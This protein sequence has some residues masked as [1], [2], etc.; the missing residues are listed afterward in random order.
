MHEPTVSEES[1]APLPT[2]EPGF[3]TGLRALPIG[4]GAFVDNLATMIG[5]MLFLSVQVERYGIRPGDEL[6]EEMLR[7]L[8]SDPSLLAGSLMIGILATGLGGYTAARVA[9]EYRVRHG[10]FVGLVGVALGLLAFG[11][12]PTAERP[13]LWFDLLRFLALIPAGALGGALA[14]FAA[15]RG[16]EKPVE[17]PAP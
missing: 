1:K 12:S 5:G 6:P 3:F 9:G 14:D 11:P 8:Q 15:H 17:P 16:A 2:D 10:A 4:I 7:A 13:P